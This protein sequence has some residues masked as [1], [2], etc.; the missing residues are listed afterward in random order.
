MDCC[1][2]RFWT[3]LHQCGTKRCKYTRYK[4][5]HSIT[6]TYGTTPIC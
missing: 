4:P 1:L 6:K 5:S 2:T 3:Q